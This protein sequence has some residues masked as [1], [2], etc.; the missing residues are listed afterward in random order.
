MA[1][2]GAF[3][4]PSRLWQSSGRS[5]VLSAAKVRLLPQDRNL[6]LAVRVGGGWA[7]DPKGEAYAARTYSGDGNLTASAGVEWRIGKN[8]ALVLDDTLLQ[9]VVDDPGDSSS[10]VRNHQLGLGAVFGR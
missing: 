1:E 10:F 4:R 2:F 9:P 5:N 6:A 8:F 7:K 3:E